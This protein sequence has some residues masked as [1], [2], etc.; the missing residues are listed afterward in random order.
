MQ[1]TASEG[2]DD[3]GVTKPLPSTLFFG[4][5]GQ[6]VDATPEAS[7]EIHSNVQP[8]GLRGVRSPC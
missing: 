2:W 3:E 7:S 1:A 4:I 5:R 6:Q 8:F